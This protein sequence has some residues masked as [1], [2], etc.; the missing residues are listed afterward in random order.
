MK[1]LLI[2]DERKNRRMCSWGFSGNSYRVRLA[3]S[4]PM[5]DVA[6]A[7]ESFHAAWREE[8]L[9]RTWVRL[10]AEQATYHAALR[11]RIEEPEL[12]SPL[13]AERLAQQLGRAMTADGV[14]KAL[15]RAH[16]RFADLLLDEVEQTLEAPDAAALEDELRA[17]DLLRYCRTALSRRSSP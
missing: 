16:E 10:H 12:T 6:L 8:L 4:R 3:N 14:R 7:N 9:E 13:M 15:Q 2:G 5:V 17:I 11:L 1:L